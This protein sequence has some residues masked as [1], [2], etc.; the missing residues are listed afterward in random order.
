MTQSRNRNPYAADGPSDIVL[1]R[2]MSPSDSPQ[3]PSPHTCEIRT[4]ELLKRPTSVA[5]YE[6]LF[7]R[8]SPHYRIQQMN[9]APH[10]PT[11]GMNAKVESSSGSGSTTNA[12]VDPD[13]S[14]K[15]MGSAKEPHPKDATA[16]AYSLANI[17]ADSRPSSPIQGASVTSIARAP[18]NLDNYDT[19]VTAGIVLEDAVMELYHE[20]LN[21]IIA[22]LD[23]AL[24]SPS[25]VRNRSS[26]L[27]TAI[28]TVACRFAQPN[29]WERCNALGQTLLGRALA[30][31]ICSIEYVQALSLLTFWKD[32]RDSSS[33]RKVG[34]AIRMAYELNLHEP[35]GEPLPTAELLAREQLNKERTW[36]RYDMTT[37][38]QRNKPQMI[39]DFHL[40]DAYEW[41][42]NHPEFP[43]NADTM[44]V[45]SAS[46]GSIRLLCHSLFS[47]MNVST[48]AA[49]EPLMRHVAQLLD[50]RIK[51]WITANEQLNLAP[52]SKAILKFQSLN[53]RLLVAE[54][55]LLNLV[56]PQLCATRTQALEC[57]KCAMDVLRHVVAELVP[58]G[59]IIYCQDM[60]AIATA[61][62][63][64]W[65]FKQLPHVDEE[66]CN[67]IV[68]TFNDV[69]NACRMLSRQKGDTP[70][71]FVQ[72][73]DHLSRNAR[74]QRVSISQAGMCARPG[75]PMHVTARRDHPD[76]SAQVPP[77][78]SG[79][80]T[81]YPGPE[82]IPPM[83]GM[84]YQLTNVMNGL[85]DWWKNF[86]YLGAD[87][88]GDPNLQV[89]NPI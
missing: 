30:D 56:Q 36:L 67:D 16:S 85:N 54:L 55:K 59:C 3:M 2:G 83:E 37:A 27:F 10:Y 76:S 50:E 53:L 45:A 15:F 28:L 32:P 68:A 87:I 62:A 49:F 72:F 47:S 73:F 44:L 9:P 66:L 74:S 48:K 57:I 78:M 38:M 1:Q 22:L 21:P 70:S 42:S 24:H 29:A 58:N 7:S 11:T 20:Y 82:L 14:L 79:P 69:S 23:P 5:L 40:S 33:W 6:H 71:Y 18:D 13:R 65:L 88:R 77:S 8:D 35:R 81:N 89:G 60:L 39:P 46:F 41:V 4:R 34:L 86:N 52:V 19:P 17:L 25:Y 75:V 43:C 12:S 31:G 80:M 51:R 84:D 26:V 63:G 64:V 61:Y